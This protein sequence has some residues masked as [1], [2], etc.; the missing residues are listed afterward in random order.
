MIEASVYV[1]LHIR[2]RLSKIYV[3]N[4]KPRISTRHVGLCRQPNSLYYVRRRSSKSAGYLGESSLTA[5]E[6]AVPWRVCV[7]VIYI[8]HRIEAVQKIAPLVAH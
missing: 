2:S 5:F 6:L 3:I 4:T 1:E 7:V 8:A